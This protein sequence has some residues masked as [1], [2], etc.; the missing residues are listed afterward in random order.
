MDLRG[1]RIPLPGSTGEI[2]RVLAVRLHTLG[3]HT[4]CADRDHAVSVTV[5]G[6]AAETA[7]ARM[8]DCAAAEAALPSR[9]T[10]V[11]RLRTGR[12]VAVPEINLPH[13]GTGFAACAVVM[14]RPGG[15]PA[16]EMVR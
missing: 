1:G 9:L 8:A 11:H 2:G 13:L 14:I 15:G 6:I 12:G 3:T 16:L 5:T 7:P 4:A 10:A